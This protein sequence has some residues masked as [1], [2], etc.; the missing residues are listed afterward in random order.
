M[1]LKVGDVVHA[2]ISG[3]E[4]SVKKKLGEGTQGVAYLVDG[5][6]GQEVV[7]W[8]FRSQGTSAQREAIENLVNRG[9]PRGKGGERFVWPKDIV[10]SSTET[11]TFVLPDASDRYFT[12]C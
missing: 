1:A 4:L 9:R 7:K 10:T 12:I 2:R 6:D 5:P 8:Y 11:G 3:Y